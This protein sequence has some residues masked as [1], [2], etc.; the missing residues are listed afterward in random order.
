M[1]P[2][3]SHRGA[4]ARPLKGTGRPEEIRSLVSGYSVEV[5]PGV[6]DRVDNFRAHL[7]PGTTV[8]ITHLPGSDFRD[9]VRVA[10]R[11][12]AEGFEPAPHVA[13][14]SLRHR[15]ELADYVARLAGEAG[16]RHVVVMAGSAAR[17][18]GE[19]TDSMQVLETGIF[20]RHG[21]RAIGV[22]GHPE[23][24]PD[25][26][27]EV[28]ARALT[29]SAPDR[30]LADLARYT[31]DSPGSGIDGVHLYPFGALARSAAWAN[32]V[33][34]GDFVMD[35]GGRGFTVEIPT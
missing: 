22:A 18:V 3:R 23:G 9:T 33:V 30:L 8:A 5:T 14:R 31:A 32:A 25:I 16:V 34:D 2:S 6:A 1:T 12:R 11:L 28:L 20:E 35:P 17:P 4:A 24:S 27:D 7:R 21:V 15:A 29:V 10:K 19:L 26:P 13:A